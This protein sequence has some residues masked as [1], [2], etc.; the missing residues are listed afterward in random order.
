[1][2]EL[3][4]PIRYYRDFAPHY[5][6][7]YETLSLKQEETALL[8]VDVDGGAPNPTTER[9]IAP[10]LAAARNVGM[11]VAY[12]HN[13]LRLVADPGNIVFEIWGKTKGMKEGAWQPSGM[14]K[15]WA[16]TY[17]DCVAP[18][19][20][21]PNFPKW[22]WSG[23]RDTM[24]DQHLRSW[25]IKTVV[26]VGYSLRA[27]F[28]GT[29]IDAVYN[30]YRVVVLRDCANAP[31]LP[32]TRDESLPE[33]GWI[34]RIFLRNIEHLVGYTATSAEFVGACQKVKG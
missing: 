24:L 9:F 10:A 18:L 23:F 19:P 21:E 5:D 12:V 22:V 1:M 17:L 32:D 3:N 27:C 25:G 33:G 31:E 8:V 4:I 14:P 11:R 15:N 26:A 16:P 2:P 7:A 29:I 6:Y 13:D 34:N 30:N 20:G 28:Y